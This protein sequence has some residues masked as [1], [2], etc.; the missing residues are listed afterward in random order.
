MEEVAIRLVSNGI[1]FRNSQ[2]EEYVT[3]KNPEVPFR[4]TLY[5]NR[6]DAFEITITHNKNK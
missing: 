1:I 2:G 4:Y 5:D 6:G 3:E